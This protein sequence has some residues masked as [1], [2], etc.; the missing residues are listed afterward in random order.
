MAS[1]EVT[2]RCKAG[3]VTRVRLIGVPRIEDADGAPRDVKGHKPWAVL[4]RVVLADRALTRRELSAELFPDADDPLGSLRW[5]LAALRRALGSSHL[6]TGDPIRPDL[7]PTITVDVHELLAG[8]VDVQGA[9]EL[10]EG[11]DP[12]CGPEFSVWLLVARQ[13][14]ASRI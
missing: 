3:H 14:V 5:C 10:L 2:Q 7:G 11:V 12:G 9:G 8:V 13:Q 1:D 4:A 6:L